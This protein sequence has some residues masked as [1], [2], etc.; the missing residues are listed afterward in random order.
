M[1]IHKITDVIIASGASCEAC[2]KGHYCLAGTIE[3]TPCPVGT[4]RGVTSAL[5]L[6]DCTACPAG[7][8]CPF[9]GIVDANGASACAY[10]HYCPAGTDYPT[11]N[12]CPAGKFSDNTN[13][14]ASSD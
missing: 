2:P 14:D 13:N 7:K 6:S 1:P 8:A 12:P 3:P 5:A 10:G 11:D 4:Y 9:V